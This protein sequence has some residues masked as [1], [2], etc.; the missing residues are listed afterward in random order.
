MSC[1]AAAALGLAGLEALRG[2][3]PVFIEGAA[4]ADTRDAVIVG[5]N[6]ARQLRLHWERRPPPPGPKVIVIEGDPYTE[7][8]ISAITRVVSEDLQLPRC[9]ITLDADLDPTHAPNADRLGVTTELSYSAVAAS[10]VPADLDRL[11]AAIETALD[12]KR[13]EREAEGRTI[14]S[15]FLKYA[16]LQEASKAALQRACG[17][18]TLA[19]TASEVYPFS[20]TS[21]HRVGTAG[22]F[23]DEAD[24]VPYGEDEAGEPKRS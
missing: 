22:G 17:R 16:L 23:Y 7:H 5:R 24:V 12:G 20:V 15:Y 11:S 13:R 4:R 18:I 8:G 14:P 1:A 3:H 2:V 21:F 19:H 10:L 6:I 9:L